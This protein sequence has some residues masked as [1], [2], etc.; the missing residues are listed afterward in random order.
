MGIFFTDKP[1]VTK[2]EFRK[3]RNYLYLQGFTH[4]ELDQVGEIFYADMD[5]SATYEKG[6]SREEIDKGI[7]W[8]RDNMSVHHISEQKIDILEKELQSK[9]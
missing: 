1:K 5:E 9:L 8:M 7:Q 4:K 3:V 6:I 2:E